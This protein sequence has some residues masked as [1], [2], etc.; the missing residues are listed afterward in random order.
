MNQMPNMN[1][2]PYQINAMNGQP[3]PVWNQQNGQMIANA[4]TPNEFHPLY[5]QHNQA[6]MQQVIKV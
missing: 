3:T 4:Q 5:H 1:Q 2:M 6:Q